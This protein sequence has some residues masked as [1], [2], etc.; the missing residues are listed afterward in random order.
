MAR[1]ITVKIAT[2]KVIKILEDKLKEL[3]NIK[4]NYPKLMEAKKKKQEAWEKAVLAQVKKEIGKATS[5]SV[6]LHMWGEP[7]IRASFTFPLDKFPAKPEGEYIQDPN[8]YQFREDYEDVTQAI[9]LLK[10]TDAEYVSTATYRSIT[11]FL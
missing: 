7:S 6:D 8:G 2:D 9:R 10:M 3:D 11:R 1:G 5:T 4:A